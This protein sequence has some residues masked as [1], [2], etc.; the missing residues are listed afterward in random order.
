MNPGITAGGQGTF[1]EVP[2]PAGAQLQAGAIPVWTSSDPAV[3]LTPSADGTTCIAAVPATDTN[4]SF[5]I[6]ATVNN[7]AG[8]S[9]SG[10]LTVPINQPVVAA[11]SLTISQ[12]A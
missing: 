11:T 7:S 10:S 12:I 3:T 4:P 2:F 8:Q 9:I 5:T 1:Q 6:T